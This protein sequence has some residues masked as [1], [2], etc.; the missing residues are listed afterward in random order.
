MQQLRCITKIEEMK[1]VRI[2]ILTVP[3]VVVRSQAYAGNWGLSIAY[4]SAHSDSFQFMDHLCYL[5]YNCAERFV[6]QPSGCSVR[7]DRSWHLHPLL[8]DQFVT[9]SAEENVRCSS[10]DHPG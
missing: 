10:G 6:F 4:S 5:T 9:T 1:E 3:G 7:T 2:L 8:P